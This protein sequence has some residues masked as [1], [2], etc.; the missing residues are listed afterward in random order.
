MFR[1]PDTYG[2]FTSTFTPVKQFSVSLTGT[3]TGHMLVQHMA[4]GEGT[5]DREKR[6]G[7][8]FDMNIKLAYNFPVFKTTTLQ[9]NTGIQNIF[10]S[11]QKDFDQGP[12][13]DSGYI[14]E[15][16]IPRS[17]FIGCRISY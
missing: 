13:R 8:F 1:S 9:V 2:Y 16:G 10:D 4:S 12:E 11:Y 6:T 5:T 14:Y 3:Y 17:Y 15:P 7:E